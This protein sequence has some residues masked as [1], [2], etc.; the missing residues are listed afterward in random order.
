MQK[1]NRLLLALDLYTHFAVRAAVV[2]LGVCQVV[3]CGLPAVPGTV[4]ALAAV[5]GHFD[6]QVCLRYHG[7]QS[8]AEHE[9][10]T[11][12]AIA[13]A[14]AVAA[15]QLAACLAQ[16]LMCALHCWQSGP[17]HVDSLPLLDCPAIGQDA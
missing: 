16:L 6:S 11:A 3:L 12:V 7:Q 1:R 2:C 5:L 15:L 9:A 17:Y 4:Q 14:A 13:A 10:V 8:Q